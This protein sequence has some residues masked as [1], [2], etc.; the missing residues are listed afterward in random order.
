MVGMID[1]TERL[2][3]AIRV[4]ATAHGKQGQHRKGTDIPYIVHPFGVMLLALQVTKEE[5]VLIACLLH[6]ILEDVDPAIYSE[7]DM[8][9]D[10]GPRVTGMVK[11]VSKDDRIEDWRERSQAYLDHLEHKASPKAVVVSAADKVH[12]LLS[13]ITDYK[14]AGDDIWQRF[15]TQNSADQLWWYRSVFALLQKR[16]PDS[17]LTLQLGNAI[18]ALEVLLSPDRKAA[19]SPAQP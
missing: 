17:V 7:Q 19:D 10:F 14:V 3:K 4:A 9:R 8:E 13:I 11:D 1:F 12:N 18:G 6:D 15:A 16:Q 2:D 5:D